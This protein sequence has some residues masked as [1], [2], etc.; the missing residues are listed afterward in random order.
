MLS[1]V[2]IE[3]LCDIL[4]QPTGLRPGVAFSGSGVPGGRMG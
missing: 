4:L 1:D 3:R 2:I